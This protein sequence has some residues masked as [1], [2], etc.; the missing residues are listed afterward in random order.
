MEHC[1][2]DTPGPLEKKKMKKKTRTMLQYGSHQTVFCREQENILSLFLVS[3]HTEE[4]I[5]KK[6][7]LDKSFF[8]FFLLLY[9]LT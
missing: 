8:K 5:V 3:Y 7:T 4:Q 2:T 1:K 9:K 6:Y